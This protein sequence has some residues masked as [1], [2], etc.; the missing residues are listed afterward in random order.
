MDMDEDTQKTVK[1]DGDVNN[2]S[3]DDAMEMECAQNYMAFSILKALKIVTAT[4]VENSFEGVCSQLLNTLKSFREL[5]FAVPTMNGLVQLFLNAVMTIDSVYCSMNHD[6][7][8]QQK[9]IFIRLLSQIRSQKPPIFSLKQRKD[10]ED[11]ELKTA[12]SIRSEV[13]YRKNKKTIS[14]N[15]NPNDSEMFVKEDTGVAKLPKKPTH[16]SSANGY[17]SSND[18]MA[19]P[20]NIKI[21]TSRSKGIAPLLDLHKDHDLDSLPSPTSKSALNF[22]MHCTIPPGNRVSNPELG[23]TRASLE[24]PSSLTH[25]FRTEGLKVFSSYHQTFGGYE[26]LP[27]PTPSEDFDNKDNDC[28]VE[29]SGSFALLNHDKPSL[30]LNTSSFPPVNTGTVQRPSTVVTSAALSS[31]INPTMT[32]SAKN[33]DPRLHYASL[34]VGSLDMKQESLVVRKSASVADR[35]GEGLNLDGPAFKRQ[36][37]GPPNSDNAR[38]NSNAGTGC[39]LDPNGTSGKMFTTKNKKASVGNRLRDPRTRVAG[40]SNCGAKPVR[41][42]VPPANNLPNS[43]HPELLKKIAV[44]PTMLLELLQ[45]GSQQNIVQEPLQKHNDVRTQIKISGGPDLVVGSVAPTNVISLKPPSTMCKLAGTLQG[46]KGLVRMK[47]RD[48][49]RVLLSGT[50]QSAKLPLGSSVGFKNIKVKVSE[51]QANMKP[52]SSQVAIPD[53]TRKNTENPKNVA[54]IMTSAQSETTSPVA[55]Q[56]Q[57]STS[58]MDERIIDACS[59]SEDGVAGPSK[60]Q[61]ICSDVEH[62]FDRYDDHQRAVVQKERARRLGEQEKMFAERKLCLVLDLDHTLLNSAKFGEIDPVHEEL[63]RKKEEQDRDKPYRH[64][65]HFP[66]MGMWTKLRPGIWNFL[67]KASQLFELHLYTM[68]NKLYASEIA[69]ILDPEGVLFAGRVISRGDDGDVIDGDDRVS[70][71]KDL[72]GVLGI[73]SSVV[74][75]DDSIRVWP[76]N[77]LNLIVV[78]RYIYFPCSRRQFGLPGPSLLE[79][80]HDERPEDGTLASSLAV[81]ERLHNT[82]FSHRDLKEVDVRAILATEQRKILS[83]CRIVFSR[84]FP[85]GEASP[86]LHPLW[87]RAEQFGASCTNQVDDK[88]THVVA[89]SLGTDKVNWAI[90]KGRFVVRP[91]W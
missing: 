21:S 27:S 17:L 57:S 91:N 26:R 7:K 19:L 59:T 81:I 23:S 60:S 46:D 31:D 62:L 71:T 45:K 86:H 16:E 1:E 34:G 5:V 35:S 56:I 12:G 75:I 49:R 25:S 40:Y 8:E 36:K 76:H 84:V 77:Q 64:L 72:E 63:L 89:N 47:P 85:V 37:Y 65:F 70:K 24:A 55:S 83:G 18:Q 44:N 9:E 43:L 78:E 28:A 54:N 33:R 80:D 6:Q 73:E 42:S 51:G 10:I 29:V 14:T 2:G 68:G 58:T 13:S 3:V 90:S 20:G 11:M 52:V 53:S 88:V 50:L 41:D 48:P 67:E 87:Q 69:K 39:W 82:F 32:A 30:L 22:S 61:T 66:H 4:E 74:I 15:V 79:I 38:E